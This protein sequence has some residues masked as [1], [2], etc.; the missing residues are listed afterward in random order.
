MATMQWCNKALSHRMPCHGTGS[1][2]KEPYVF[3]IRRLVH[4]PQEIAKAAI[5]HQ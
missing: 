5:C 2:V 3:I 4:V 1:G